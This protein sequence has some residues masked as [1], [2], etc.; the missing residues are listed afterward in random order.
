MKNLISSHN[1]DKQ[2][3]GRGRQNNKTQQ[4][5]EAS[6]GSWAEWTLSC[7]RYIPPTMTLNAQLH[8]HLHMQLLTLPSCNL[9]LFNNRKPGDT[10]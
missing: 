5:S 2:T 10:P 7:V 1:Q 9:K 6:E 4:N 3:E 8:T